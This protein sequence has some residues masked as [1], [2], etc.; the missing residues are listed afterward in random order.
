MR[1]ETQKD[2]GRQLDTQGT[3][4][5]NLPHKRTQED[6]QWKDSGRQLDLQEDT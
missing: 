5:D 2:T 4:G 6:N 3:Q 1:P